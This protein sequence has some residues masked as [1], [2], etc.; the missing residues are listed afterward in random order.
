MTATECSSKKT[1]E[2]ASN[3]KFQHEVNEHVLKSTLN[4]KPCK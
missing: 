4:V 1:T 2:C 3:D